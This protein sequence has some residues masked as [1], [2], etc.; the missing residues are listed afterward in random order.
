MALDTL[1]RTA[2]PRSVWLASGDLFPYSNLQS[3]FFG[4]MDR[5]LLFGARDRAGD[6]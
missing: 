2:I 1:V 4:E 5:K 3:T 6:M